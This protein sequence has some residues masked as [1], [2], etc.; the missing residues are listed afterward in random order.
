M[1]QDKVI[2]L[3]LFRVFAFLTLAAFI[4]TLATQLI[5]FGLVTTACGILS[6]TAKTIYDAEQ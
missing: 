1:N 4:F 6:I 2:A 3:I 5:G